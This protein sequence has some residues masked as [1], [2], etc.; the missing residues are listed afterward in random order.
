VVLAAIV[1]TLAYGT[2]IL[3]RA[4]LESAGLGRAGLERCCRDRPRRWSEHLLRAAGTD[5]VVEGGQHLVEGSQIVVANHESWFDVLALAARLPVEYRFVAKK[6][7]GRVPLWGPAWKACGHISIDREDRQ[8]AIESLQ[9]A[10]RQIREESVTIV[11]FPEGTRSPTGELRPFKKGAF[12]LAIQAG[13]PVVPVGI[14][15]SRRVM[16]KGRWRVR[17]GT[18]RVRIGEPIPVGRLEHR[19]RDRL[20]REAERRVAALRAASAPMEAG[21]DE[22][23]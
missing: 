8:S 11:M 9:R 19:D 10:G 21:E 22:P 5:V 15:G 12:V 6:E 1:W 23:G 16:P 17:A 2:E 14:S 18:I 13:A 4:A 20:A 3:V 7:L